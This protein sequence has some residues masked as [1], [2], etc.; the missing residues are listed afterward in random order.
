ML[1]VVGQL[2]SPFA[3]NAQDNKSGKHSSAESA[4][5]ATPI[6]YVVVIFDENNAFDHYFGTYP[7][8]LNPPG[9]PA[10]Y[11]RPGTPTVNGLTEGLINHNPNSAAFPARSLAGFHLRQR[12]PLHR[13][14]EGLRL[15]PD[16]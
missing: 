3:S 9:E 1:F 15:R 11:A 14:A 10:F 4:P 16:R 12:Q 13:R 5:T 6:K 8:A 7:N 2:I